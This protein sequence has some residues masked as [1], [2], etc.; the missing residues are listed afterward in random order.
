MKCKI[1]Y[2]LLQRKPDF[3]EL[4]GKKNNALK[5]RVVREIGNKI[6]VFDRG[7]GKDIWLELSGSPA[8]CPQAFS[9]VPNDRDTGQGKGFRKMEGTRNRDYTV[10]F[11]TK[12]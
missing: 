4:K 6:T 7:E 9:N 1:E 10:Y 8:S 5:N 11:N 2:F 3:S 12:T